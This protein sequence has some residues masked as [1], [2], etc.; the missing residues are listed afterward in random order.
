MNTSTHT[1]IARLRCLVGFLGE[2]S[3]YNWW[4]S[5]FFTPSSRAFLTPMFSK[6]AFTA[7]YQGVKE[8]ASRVHDEHIGVGKV[9]HL[10]RLPE[11]TEQALGTCVQEP[12]FVASVTPH[13]HDTA[14]ALES[15]STL[16]GS[17]DESTEG[18]VLVGAIGELAHKPTLRRLA[19]YYCSAFTGNTRTYPYYVDRT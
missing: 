8:A 7:Q 12:A 18:P 11:Y 10:F 14:S 2:Q 16:A 9:Y 1:R 15:L 3:Q 17:S 6:T 13:L 5:A 4:P 19:Q